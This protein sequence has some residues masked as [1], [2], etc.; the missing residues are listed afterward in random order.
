MGRTDLMANTP[1]ILNQ[2]PFSA[3]AQQP[4]QFTPNLESSILNMFGQYG[5][6]VSQYGGG[7]YADPAAR[8]ARIANEIRSGQRSF[9]DV[10]NSL[11]L[12]QR[13]QSPEHTRAYQTAAYEFNP[14]WQQ[15]NR[16]IQQLNQGRTRDVDMAQRFGNWGRQA[17]GDTY[18][19][20]Q[21]D[22]IENRAA[23]DA[24]FAGSGQRIGQAFDQSA[25]MAEAA[26]QAAMAQNAG[27]A[28]SLG[29]KEATVDPQAQLGSA[30]S[31]LLQQQGTERAA[32]QGTLE[33]MRSANYGIN[34]QA[35]SDAGMESALMQDRHMLSA[36]DMLNDILTQ[37]N[38]QN[39]DVQ[40]Q[41]SDL[42]A[43]RGARTSELLNQ[44]RDQ[45]YDRGRQENL[46]RLA[47]EIQRGTLDLQRQELG[48]N[49][50]QFGQEMGLNWAQ[51]G[52]DRDLGMGQLEIR[53]Q[54]IDAQLATEQDPLKRQR[55]ILENALLEQE[56]RGSQGGGT[57]Y[58]QAGVDA[59][60][61]TQY[62]PYQ[63][64]KSPRDF[65]QSVLNSANS[66]AANDPRFGG[67]ASAAADYYVGQLAGAG[68]MNP[69]M[70]DLM[71]RLIDAYYMTTA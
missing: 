5:V 37:Y 24:A 65:W 14:Q 1:Q 15:L 68:G 45:S 60:L 23:A 38:Q 16:T 17:I 30:V 29:V 18:G 69:Q 50:E 64:G 32:S 9:T 36:S 62:G 43:S 56:L 11:K 59:I 42:E 54:E 2:L 47:E 6:D 51:L 66:L 49:R 39:F 57:Q 58:G 33:N 31:Q 46:D 21:Q 53:R 44:F 70:T 22:F 48:F 12:A 3:Y 40:G 13:S 71:R 27:L 34:T 35:I 61:N 25:Q 4:Q 67:N 7:V 41:L 8:L 20:L 52:L 55:L 19:N 28:A 10:E 63:Q 26:K